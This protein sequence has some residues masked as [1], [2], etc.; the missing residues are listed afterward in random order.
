MSTTEPP[1][2]RGRGRGRGR[3]LKVTEST[4]PGVGRGTGR[5]RSKMNWSGDIAGTQPRPNSNQIS[6]SNPNPE[7]SEPDS[8]FSDTSLVLYPGPIS[9]PSIVKPGLRVEMSLAEKEVS[10]N[11]RKIIQDKKGTSSSVLQKHFSMSSNPYLSALTIASKNFEMSKFRE[12]SVTATVIVEFEKW[13]KTKCKDDLSATGDQ[14]TLEEKDFAFFTFSMYTNLA[15]IASAF[16]V[17]DIQVRYRDHVAGPIA[18]PPSPPTHTHIH[19]QAL[20]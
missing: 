12:N 1:R 5:G 14:L 2:G 7:V 20:K 3:T 17:F 4:N 16:R 15:V 10:S 8:Q 18:N 13:L 11:I 19:I 6:I 9:A